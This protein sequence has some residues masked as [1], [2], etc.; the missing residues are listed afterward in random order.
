MD[1]VPGA[2]QSDDMTVRRRFGAVAAAVGCGAVPFMWN[3]PP[4]A[5][6]EV[7]DQSKQF[8]VQYRNFAG[9]T[10]T[11]GVTGQST[12]FRSD[13]STPYEGFSL[14][15]TY[16]ASGSGSG[17]EALVFV[18]ATYIGA[19]GERRRSSSGGLQQV[20]LENDDVRTEY[21]AT[22]RVSFQDCAFDCVVEFST[23]PK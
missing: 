21:A 8:E 13:T 15:F 5:A 19:N 18:T 23:R 6:R 10:V 1:V 9:Q 12:L 11:C 7:F 16:E 22:H 14:T 17:C 2:R 3:V 20:S 4:A